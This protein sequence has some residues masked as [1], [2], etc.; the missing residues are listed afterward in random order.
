MPGRTA[1]TPAS[2]A[3][4]RV[5]VMRTGVDPRPPGR[6][7]QAAAAAVQ[8]RARRPG[9]VAA[10]QYFS[11]ISMSDWVRAATHLATHDGRV[12][13]LQR[14]RRRTPRP[15]RSSAGSSAGCCTGRRCCRCPAWPIRTLAGDVSRE[16]LELHAGRAGPAARRGVRLR[17]PHA[18]PAAAPPRSPD[19]VTGRARAPARRRPRRAAASPRGRPAGRGAATTRRPRPTAT[20]PASRSVTASRSRSRPR[21]THPQREH[22]GAHAP[23]RP[24]PARR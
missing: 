20:A 14:L 8:G 13:R 19:R 21:S 24:E 18:R 9:R 10:T 16:L 6:A 1:T 7:A 4:A 12:R 3:G 23:R 15:T 2:E 5:A 22:L 11:T 17:A